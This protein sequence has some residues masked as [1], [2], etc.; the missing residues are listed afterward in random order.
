M[1]LAKILTKRHCICNAPKKE[2]V[3]VFPFPGQ[4]KKQLLNLFE[5][6]LPFCKLKLF[7]KSP[8]KSLSQFLIKDVRPKK[9]CSGIITAMLFI[10]AKGSAIFTSVQPNTRDFHIS[11]THF[12][13]KGVN[14]V[15]WSVISLTNL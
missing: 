8:A 3:C 11:E 9:F 6:T 12:I 2:L 4:N 1:F 15:K 13:N 7:W 14:D 5:R 10:T